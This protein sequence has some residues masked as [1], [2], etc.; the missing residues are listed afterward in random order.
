MWEKEKSLV[1]SNF[2]FFHRL[3]S[4]GLFPRGFK[5]CR[6]LC[7]NG[8]KRKLESGQN[9]PPH[10][11]LITLPACYCITLHSLSNDEFLDWLKLK[12]FADDK[13]N[14]TEKQKFFYGMIGKHYGKRRKCWLPALFPFPT[15]FS[16]AFFHRVVKSRYC[17]VMISQL[18]PLSHMPILGSSNWAANKNML[19]KIWT[20]GVQLSD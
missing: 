18:Y 6:P 11:T 8:L 20:N 13:I 16:K 19:S 12:S 15:M 3:F 1:T 10:L 7:G 14:V 17:V 5:R 2:S 9:K 4:K